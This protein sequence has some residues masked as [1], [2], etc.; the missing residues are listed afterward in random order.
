MTSCCSVP[1]DVVLASCC[2]L[3]QAVVMT[4]CCCVPQDVVLESC[5]PLSQDVVMTSC[6]CVP[7]DAPSGSS[8]L[9]FESP[10]AM[11]RESTEDASSSSS[12]SRSYECPLYCTSSRAG[13]LSSTGISTNY[14][15]S[16]R[17]PSRQPAQLWTVRGVA[18]LCQLDE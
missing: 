16:V 1:Q 13:T 18:L 9:S 4:S 6:C 8:A 14:V 15:T 10:L 3:Y 12:S 2:P 17:L 5:C 11:F 7:Q